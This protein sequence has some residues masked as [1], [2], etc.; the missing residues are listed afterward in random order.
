MGFAF[1]E[2]LVPEPRKIACPSHLRG[3]HETAVTGYAA[4]VP[5][6]LGGP[7][8]GN[9]RN[10]G[11]ISCRPT[12]GRTGDGAPCPGLG[13]NAAPRE[14][15]GF[16]PGRDA[17]LRLKSEWRAPRGSPAPA[18]PREAPAGGPPARRRDPPRRDSRAW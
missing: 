13:R 14:V 18:S 15:P 16:S 10:D 4:R 11:R 17:G 2:E 3:F 1:A 12:G 9:P 5:G 8:A 7:S 6:G